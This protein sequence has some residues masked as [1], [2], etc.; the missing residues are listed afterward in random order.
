MEPTNGLV[1]DL[2][3]GETFT[4]LVPPSATVQEILVTQL[5]ST[6]YFQSPRAHLLV[7]AQ[8]T[9]GIWRE[10]ILNSRLDRGLPLCGQGILKSTLIQGTKP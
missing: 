1:V 6:R 2:N 5:P 7:N 4:I 10:K 3:V 8:P 9:V